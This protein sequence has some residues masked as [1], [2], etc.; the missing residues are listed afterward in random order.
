MK[1]SNLILVGL[2]LAYLV[3]IGAIP[4]TLRYKLGHNDFSVVNSSEAYPYT[5]HT[6]KKSEYIVLQGL[7]NCTIIPSDSLFLEIE[8]TASNRVDVI[9]RTDTLIIKDRQAEDKGS[10]KIRL[11]L[12]ATQKITARNST[13]LL[14]GSLGAKGV[15]YQFELTSSK[16]FTKV[17]A[18]AP[19]IAQYLDELTVT[20][21][22]N[23][24]LDL[25]GIISMNRLIVSDVEQFSY[26]GGFSS[27]D[28]DISYH[29]KKVVESKGHEGT[30]VV[31]GK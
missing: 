22:K 8:K 19:R 27:T 5:H 10:Q 12:P 11:Y 1:T 29:D 9:Q 25:Q 21:F 3:F 17:L 2:S 24:A 31:V 13:I 28:V 23:S 18:E 26:G 4:I 15:T 7:T 14:R 16:L 30:V 6:V 20:G